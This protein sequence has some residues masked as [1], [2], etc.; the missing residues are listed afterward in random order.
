MIHQKVKLEIQHNQ[1]KLEDIA[2]VI[3]KEFKNIYNKID[4]K[5]NDTEISENIKQACKLLIHKW[6]KDHRDKIILFEFISNHLVDISVNILFDKETKKLLDEL[7]IS[8]PE[9]LIEMI[10]FQCDPHA[11]FFYEDSIIDPLDESSLDATRDISINENNLQNIVNFNINNNNNINNNININNNNHN[12]I[13]NHNDNHNNINNNNVYYHQP[14]RRIYHGIRNNNNNYIDW[15]R[16]RYEEGLKKYCFAQAVIYEKLLDSHLFS[17]I[18]WIN[19]LNEDQEGELITLRNGHRYKVKKVVADFEFKVKT[20]QNREYKIKVKRGENSRNSY[21]KYRFS[22]SEWNL[23]KGDS[24]M[25]FAFVN[26][27]FENEPEIVLSKTQ[28]LSEL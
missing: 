26:L 4:L 11:P 3:D 15:T 22:N 9:S 6:F 8:E 19:K 5:G 23:F 12:N 1:K 10:K 17:E 21:L 14:Q 20:N 16:I 25:I 18:E 27:K 2:F 13:N 28:K 24:H 7:L